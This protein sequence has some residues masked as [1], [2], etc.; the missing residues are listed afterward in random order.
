MYFLEVLKGSWMQFRDES[1]S[2]SM[3][4]LLFGGGGAWR[5]WFN[6]WWIAMSSAVRME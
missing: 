5:I 3:S 1:E 2:V 6:A 4:N